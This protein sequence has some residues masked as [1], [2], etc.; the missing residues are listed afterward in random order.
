MAACRMYVSV[1]AP[2][3]R[4]KFGF[5]SVLGEANVRESDKLIEETEKRSGGC[6]EAWESDSLMKFVDC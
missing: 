4:R 1:W 5:G 6:A 2:S 3:L